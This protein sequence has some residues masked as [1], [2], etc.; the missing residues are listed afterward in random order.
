V[1]DVGK[2]KD[3]N[4]SSKLK[5]GMVITVEP[6]LYFGENQNLFSNHCVRIED[7]VVVTKTGSNILSKTAPKEIEDIESIL[8]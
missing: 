7:D 3:N 2:Y 5:E 4:K 1:H 6:G 8:N